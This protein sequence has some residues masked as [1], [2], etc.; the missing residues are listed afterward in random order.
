MAGTFLR[1]G[2]RESMATGSSQETLEDP[3]IADH[4]IHILA[5]R[6]EV[7]PCLR[8]IFR[9]A[10]SYDRVGIAGDVDVFIKGSWLFPIFSILPSPQA[11]MPISKRLLPKRPFPTAY[12]RML[13][14]PPSPKLEAIGSFPSMPT[15]PASPD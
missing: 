6:P 11:W 10:L 3:F 4:P 5:D 2:P 13:T 15:S 9:H 12:G 14:S 8:I 1:N 7:D